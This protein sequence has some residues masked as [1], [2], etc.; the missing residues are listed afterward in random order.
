MF[1]AGNYK[2]VIFNLSLQEGWDDPAV[3]FAYIDK[4]MGS[5]VQVEQVIGRALRQPGARH[6][7]DVDL[8]TATFFVRV[9]DK[10]EF[11]RILNMVR[12]RLGAEL[13]EVEIRGYDDPR[14]R[15]RATQEPKQALQVP[16]IHIDAEDA[17]EA[18][19]AVM[20]AV[21]DYR[22]DDLNT[23]GAGD[24]MRAVQKI[25]DGS[26]ATVQE[27]VAPHSNRVM[28][29][30]VVRRE[31][32][33]LFPK[34]V[35]AVEWDDPRFDARVEIT[36]AAA[37]ALRDDAEKLVCAYLEGSRLVF[38]EGN[39]YTV[40]AIHVNPAKARPFANALHDAYDLNGLEQEVAEALDVTGHPWARNPSQSGYSIPLLDV[41]DTQRFFPDFLVWK[42]DIV[43]AVDPKG[44]NLLAKDA[45]R[46]LLNI[47]DERRQRKVVVRLVTR[48][49]WNDQLV[50]LGA[51]G[52][53]VWSVFPTTGRPKARHVTTV[54]AAVATALKV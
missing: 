12:Q 22:R 25:G 40:G 7:P 43:F 28:A 21:H 30:W 26:A 8:N 19:D 18:M 23:V 35:A 16:E 1:T 32:R 15:Q 50:Q 47:M 5:A 46:K 9:D 14:D 49:K 39:P 53:T 4:S 3:S 38:E 54:T 44:G 24:A 27:L 45:G 41:G 2:H 42:D 48:G 34:S 36:S 11:P 33:T 31:M 51:A 20:A 52:F 10:Q 6:Y 13:P 17:E 29:R 37:T